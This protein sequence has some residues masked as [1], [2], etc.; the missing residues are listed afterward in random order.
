M[1]NMIIHCFKMFLWKSGR[2]DFGS[3]RSYPTLATLETASFGSNAK[4][5]YKLNR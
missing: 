1:G 3:Q 2:E 4:V 5:C